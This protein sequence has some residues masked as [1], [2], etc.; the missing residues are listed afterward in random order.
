M[1]HLGLLVPGITELLLG[2]RRGDGWRDGW[3]EREVDGGMEGWMDLGMEGRT[4][5]G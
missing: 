5:E 1:G 3:M 2:M 4:E